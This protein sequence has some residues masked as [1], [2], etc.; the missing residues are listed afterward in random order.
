M[1]ARPGRAGKRAKRS[2]ADVDATAQKLLTYV[3]AN[4]GKRMDEI[5]TALGTTVKD[6]TLP[7]Q[8]LLAAKA[9]KT[10]GRRRGTKYHVGG[11]AAPKAAAPAKRA[12]KA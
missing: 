11:G 5:A 7:A 10:S 2:T 3:K 8:R 6:L 9:V 1:A 12:K 4:D